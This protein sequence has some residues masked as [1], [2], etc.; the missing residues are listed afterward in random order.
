ML[1]IVVHERNFGSKAMSS[2]R[3]S[4]CEYCAVKA[5]INST[6]NWDNFFLSIMGINFGSAFLSCCHLWMMHCAISLR[7]TKYFCLEIFFTFLYYTNY[8]S[9]IAY[10]LGN[11]LVVVSCRRSEIISRF[12]EGQNVERMDTGTSN[13]P[14][15]DTV[16]INRQ[17]RSERRYLASK[18]VRSSLS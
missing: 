3:P 17:G 10:M 12:E 9:C 18:H 5:S 13:E 6:L 7:T 15:A 14:S 8:V 1:H 2:V 4:A 16:L 11:V